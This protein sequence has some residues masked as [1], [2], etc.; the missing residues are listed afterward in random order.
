L[1]APQSV[2]RTIWEL[3]GFIIFLDFEII[4]ST[5]RIYLGHPL[6]SQ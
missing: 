5:S 4:R 1:A 2:Q 6:V 3:F